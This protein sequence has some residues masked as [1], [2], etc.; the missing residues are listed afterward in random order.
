MLMYE[1]EIIVNSL[2]SGLPLDKLSHLTED[3]AG[4]GGQY[5]SDLSQQ[6]DQILKYIKIILM[7]DFIHG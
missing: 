3:I 5:T 1:V 6:S 7:K 2:V 4:E